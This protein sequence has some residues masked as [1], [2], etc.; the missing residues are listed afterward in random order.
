MKSRRSWSAFAA[1]AVAASGFAFIVS[2]ASSFAQTSSSEHRH[3]AHDQ[4]SSSAEI[5][6]LK[7][8]R[9][10]GSA[11]VFRHERT[12]VTRLDDARFRMDDCATQR[13]LS[14]AGI[15]NS[16]QT[17]DY[18]RRLGIAVGDVY[19]S[20]MC[21]CVET[22]R[23]AFGRVQALPALMGDWAE[24]KRSMEDGGRDLRAL[25]GSHTKPKITVVFVSHFANVFS[26]FGL[27]LAEGDAAVVRLD[28]AGAP[29]VVGV[30]SAHRWG[31]LLRDAGSQTRVSA[32]AGNKP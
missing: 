23:H 22:A 21:R 10:G 24:A 25:I 12:D 28:G 31:D 1:F 11:L 6:A 29:V 27:R 30:I 8:L 14:V 13:N 9:E 4:H 5:D 2:S 20:P 32:P 16:Q 18:V 17:G 3:G 26:A 15:A 19:A 7:A